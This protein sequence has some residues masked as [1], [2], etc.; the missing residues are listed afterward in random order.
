MGTCCGSVDGDCCTPAFLKACPKDP[1]K[2]GVT[3]KLNCTSHSDC[4]KG[5]GIVAADPDFFV[6]EYCV[7]GKCEMCDRRFP[8]DPSDPLG[9]CDGIGGDCCSAE[10]QAQCP[11]DPYH[12]KACK[13]HADCPTGANI[14]T[15]HNSQV[16][17]SEYCAKGG[18]CASCG[19][20]I[21]A[22]VC[23]A[24]DDKCCTQTFIE[25]CGGGGAREDLHHCGS[26]SVGITG[27]F[28]WK[29]SWA[30]K[31]GCTDAGSAAY[32]EPTTCTGSKDGSQSE[33]SMRTKLLVSSLIYFT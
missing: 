31:H 3:G 8:E 26:S 21:T 28:E 9:Q 25:Q 23:D 32:V 13:S 5:N 20:N 30:V 10:F 18:Q 1:S 11:T 6:G 17:W 4:P 12:C 24:F 15:I 14:S 27:S 22:L 33:T 19:S 29:L 7:A 2:C 16:K